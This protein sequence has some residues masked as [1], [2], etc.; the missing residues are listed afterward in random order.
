MD[1]QRLEE[2]DANAIGNV[3]QIHE[4]QEID[5]L[6]FAVDG[7]RA[8]DFSG[9]IQIGAKQSWRARRRHI[10]SCAAA[11]AAYIRTRA[12]SRLG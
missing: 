3:M 5:G 8:A 1:M 10:R 7:R 9:N 6:E 2:T 12:Q 4:R 11:L